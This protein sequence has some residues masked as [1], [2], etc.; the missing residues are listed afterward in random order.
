MISAP[1]IMVVG[2]GHHG[3]GIARLAGDHGMEIGCVVDP[4][5]AGTA[6]QDVLGVPVRHPVV[7][8]SLEEAVHAYAHDL[9]LAILAPRADFADFQRMASLCVDAGFNVLTIVEDAFYPW[10]AYREDAERLD[11][12]ARARGVTVAA[13]GV[14]D[15]CWTKLVVTMS[16]T[17]VGLTAIRVRQHHGVDTYPIEFLR[18]LGIGARPETFEDAIH[19]VTAAPSLLGSA[20]LAIADDLELSGKE[21]VREF[22]PIRAD[23]A[24]PSVTFGREFQVGEIIGLR[25]TSVLETAEGVTLRAE[26][27]T[28]ARRPGG[29]DVFEAVFEASPRTVLTHVADPGP[30]VVDAS[31]LHRIHDVL[32]APA[33]YL[34]PDQ[35]PAPRYRRREKQH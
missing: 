21:L 23:D 2:A 9:D 18:S 25:E 35:L 7:A 8:G 28:T 30:A 10:R 11:S 27:D 12:R 24:L 19:D 16:A 33:G 22:A 17:V 1:R 20:L 3:S 6:A 4:M 34:R 31:A 15:I 13:T 14:Q 5:Y 32:A 29:D 26:H